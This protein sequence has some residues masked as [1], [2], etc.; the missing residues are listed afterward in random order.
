M[1]IKTQV[2]GKEYNLEATFHYERRPHYYDRSYW[3]VE[4][5][6]RPDGFTESIYEESHA[7]QEAIYAACQKISQQHQR[8]ENK[9]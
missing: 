8:L 3:V 9:Q 5:P 6:I 4:L 2:D 1:L 7:V